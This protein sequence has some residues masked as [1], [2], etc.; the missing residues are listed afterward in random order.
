[1]KVAGL[2]SL[3]A[4]IPTAQAVGSHLWY[5]PGDDYDCQSYID[6][7]ADLAAA[8]GSDCS[9][10]DT[11]S[12]ALAHWH[13]NG[14]REG[15]LSSAAQHYFRVDPITLPTQWTIEAWVNIKEI[16]SSTSFLSFSIL[17]NVNCFK[18]QTDG[19]LPNEWLN[20]ILTWDGSTNKIFF[21][22]I[23]RAIGPNPASSACSGSAGS[24]MFG[25]AQDG[26]D[27]NAHFD[28]EKAPEMYLDTVAIYDK[29]LTDS[30][31]QDHCLRTCI[32]LED[33]NL[34]GA[35][36]DDEGTDHSDNDNTATVKSAT[37]GAGEY[38]YCEDGACFH[39][40]G[41]VMLES[42]AKRRFSELS[43]GDVI[44][45]SDGKGA[46]SFSPVLTLPHAANS[47]HAAFLNLTTETGKSVI[48]TPDHYI[49]KCNL[50]EVTASELVV[51][52]CLMTMDGKETLMEV[53]STEKNGVYTA[54]TQDKFL[55]VDGIVASPYSKKSY[56]AKTT[57]EWHLS[58]KHAVSY[59]KKRLRGHA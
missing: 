17:A 6:R 48:M 36:Y 46:F 57:V 28:G 56:P 42:G 44:K 31:I 27:Q 7:Y 55:V 59:L 5:F 21:N 10:G 33:P 15:R 45:T 52:D 54:T 11:A 50:H 35:W 4:L 2:F 24:L 58:A 3:A 13:N 12:R 26:V 18:M 37:S 43:I 29:A 22:G 8:F 49:P 34:F 40:D 51:G 38:G 23:E 41:T 30:E 25:Q 19:I 47:E 32:D 9:T 14:K 1:M 53:R 20:V 39:A 16:S